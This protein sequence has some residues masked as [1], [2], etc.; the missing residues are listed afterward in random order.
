MTL[1]GWPLVGWTA[2]AVGLAV[3][4]ILLVQGTGAEGVGAWLRWTARIS[5]LLFYLAVSASALRAFRDGPATRAL[6]ANRR[7]VGVSAA[8][9]H[10]WH[11]AGI[12]AYTAL[13]DVRL[14]AGAAVGGGLA[15]L[16]LFAMAATSFDRSA[17]W[18]GA[19][20]WKWLHTVGAW[21]VWLVFTFTFLGGA[22]RSVF[23]AALLALGVGVL[24]LRVALAL[25]R[26]RAP[27]SAEA[28]A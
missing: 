8:V 13:P 18:L 14:E 9:A 3:A 27:H 19:R 26:R 15:Y 28:S 16:F 2:G 22:G 23:S 10:T 5:G 1:R 21:Y 25:R 7:Y 24:G 17:A 6:L 4:G 12:A 20:R 11:L